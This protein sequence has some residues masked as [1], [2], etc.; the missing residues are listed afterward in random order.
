MTL[1]PTGLCIRYRAHAELLTL[2]NPAC[3]VAAIA[4]ALLLCWLL[5]VALRLLCPGLAPGSCWPV[6]RAELRGAAV[7]G[8]YLL[9]VLP[10]LG[11][12][13]HGEPLRTPPPLPSSSLSRC[14]S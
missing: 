2:T 7:C 11:F 13:Q 10:T 1:A 4:T 6:G 9:A 12:V 3:A 14:R 5:L 8:A